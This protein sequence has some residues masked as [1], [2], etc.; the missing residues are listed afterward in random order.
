MGEWMVLLFA[1]SKKYDKVLYTPHNW[2]SPSLNNCH[3]HEISLFFVL[4]TYVEIILM[5]WLHDLIVT[6]LCQTPGDRLYMQYPWGYALPVSH[7]ISTHES[8][9]QYP[10]GY[11]VP[12][13]KVSF[14]LHS[15][16]FILGY[17]IPSR[18]LRI[19]DSQ[20]LRIWLKGTSYPY[21]YW[22][23]DSR[24]LMIWLMGTVYPHRYWGYDS[25][26]LRIW[27]TGTEDMTHG[28]CISSRVL[29]IWLTG[30]DD[31]TQGYWGYDSRVLHILT[32]T[33]DMTHGYWW[34]DSR[35]MHIL[36]GT[37]YSLY[38]VKMQ[39][40]SNLGNFVESYGHLCGILV[41][42]TMTIH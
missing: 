3:L 35:V 36:T 39:F 33:E 38:R 11:A 5:R 31:M 42:F 12:V 8:Y 10:W 32:A 23:Y 4:S 15:Y 41:H 37:A 2:L 6:K 17:C 20:A 40:L 14:I 34:Y 7:I 24:I 9:P 26:V 22:G 1:I 30:T 25:W 16:K 21:E 29:R 28:Y 18:V 27:L 19:S 13:K